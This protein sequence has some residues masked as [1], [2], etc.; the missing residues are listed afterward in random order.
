MIIMLRFGWGRSSRPYEEIRLRLRTYFETTP[1]LGEDSGQEFRVQV[2]HDEQHRDAL[3]VR[4][5]SSGT[6]FDCASA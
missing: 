5:R 1:A 6:G 2:S 3:D 4:I